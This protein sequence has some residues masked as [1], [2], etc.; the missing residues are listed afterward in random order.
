MPTSNAPSVRLDRIA[1]T[2]LQLRAME[3]M[4]YQAADVINR[5]KAEQVVYTK[6]AVPPQEVQNG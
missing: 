1:L 2:E 6:I 3:L 4:L 5:L